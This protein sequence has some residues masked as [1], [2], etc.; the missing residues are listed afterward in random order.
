[1]NWI[2]CLYLCELPRGNYH[3]FLLAGK[4]FVFAVAKS[5][6]MAICGLSLFTHRM[7]LQCVW[8]E[9]IHY[10][11]KVVTASYCDIL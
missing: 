11:T 2:G 10:Q 8:F 7:F 4:M 9:N 5:T 6:L 1:M 3:N